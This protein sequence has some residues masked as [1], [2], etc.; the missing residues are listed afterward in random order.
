MLEELAVSGGSALVSAMA[1]DVWPAARSRV[2]RL[3]RRSG[4]EQQAGIETRLDEHAALVAEM[5]DGEGDEVRQ[6]LAPQWTLH[7]RLLLRH[8]PEAAA[9]LQALLDEINGA[10]PHASTHYVQHVVAK[11]GGHSYGAQNGK[12]IVNHGP[13]TP[14]SDVEPGGPGTTGGGDTR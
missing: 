12:I 2:A 4:T 14:P 1:T 6:A 5:S 11:D 13:L 8:H 3:F 7:L 10:L 9:E